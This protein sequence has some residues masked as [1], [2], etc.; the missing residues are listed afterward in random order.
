MFASHDGSNLAMLVDA[1]YLARANESESNPGALDGSRAVRGASVKRRAPVG[2]ETPTKK[3]SRKNKI[4]TRPMM[5]HL[6]VMNIV[7]SSF[8]GAKPKANDES[9]EEAQYQIGELLAE[10]MAEL[11]LEKKAKSPP[12]K[13][14]AATEKYLK[15]DEMGLAR[16]TYLSAEIRKFLYNRIKIEV[17][18]K[19]VEEC[20][21]IELKDEYG[22]KKLEKSLTKQL[23]AA[24]QR[25]D[26]FEGTFYL[27]TGVNL[28]Q[29]D[30]LSKK[31]K[32]PLFEAIKDAVSDKVIPEEEE[33]EDDDDE[34][35][36]SGRG[37]ESKTVQKKPKNMP[38]ARKKFEEWFDECIE[39]DETDVMFSE[40]NKAEGRFW[41]SS[42][43]PW[44]HYTSWCTAM[45]VPEEHCL[46]YRCSNGCQQN[47]CP[48]EDCQKFKVH[49]C[50]KLGVEDFWKDDGGNRVYRAYF[51]N[52][53]ANILK[54]G[55]TAKPGKA[56]PKIVLDVKY[57]KE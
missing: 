2:Q 18:K 3:K 21:A 45:N 37:G 14:K 30:H 6:A 41:F 7:L 8:Q 56:K 31:Q 52:G 28:L 38:V 48:L 32:R 46:S 34:E 23:Q 55:G 25:L 43:A 17:R 24:A 49:W 9:A 57:K 19:L 39:P 15:A 47:G 20:L 51:K 53:K 11:G 10:E 33:S 44:K 12:Q 22:L 16:K 1:A 35:E 5:H 54:M 40:E 26:K 50:H 29:V 4:R 42:M 27:G 13:L 36:E